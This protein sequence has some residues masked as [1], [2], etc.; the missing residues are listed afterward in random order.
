M[1]AQPSTSIDIAKLFDKAAKPSS[2]KVSKPQPRI[3]LRLTFEEHE[4]LQALS[5]DMTASAYIRKR[6][7]GDAD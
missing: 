5:Q 7:F 1:K 2:N 3:T 4:K 6:L